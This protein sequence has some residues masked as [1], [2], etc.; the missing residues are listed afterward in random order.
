[1]LSSDLKA[2]TVHGLLD[3]LRIHFFHYEERI[4]RYP[5]SLPN[6]QDV[7]KKAVSEKKKW[8]IQIRVDGALS[9][10]PWQRERHQAKGLTSRSV[11][12][13]VRYNPLY[14]S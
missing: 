5:D 7:W 13:H 14:I 11:T 12:M 8:R 3:S 10:S 6:L 9:K 2:S 4:K 1:M